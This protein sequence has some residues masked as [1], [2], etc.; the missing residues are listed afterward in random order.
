LISGSLLG[1]DSH[2]IYVK[3]GPVQRQQQLHKIRLLGPTKLIDAKTK[4]YVVEL[5]PKVQASVAVRKLLADRAFSLVWSDDQPVTRRER[6]QTVSGAKT[7]FDLIKPNLD[8]GREGIAAHRFGDKDEKGA[9]YLGGYLYFLQHRAY[10]YDRM[11]WSAYGRA[12]THASQMAPFNMGS[13]S[14]AAT[15]RHSLAVGAITASPNKWSFLGPKN[16]TFPYIWGFGQGPGSGRVNAAVY[17][18]GSSSTMYIGGAMGGLWKSTDTGNTWSPLGDAWQFMCVSSIAI[19]P[20]NTKNIYVGTGDFPGWYSFS[21]GIMKST[22]GGV[23]WTNYGNS[24]FGGSC[25]SSIL[26]DPE[27]PSI[28]TITTGD[29]GYN[30]ESPGKVW[31]ST[32]GGVTWTA[33]I[34]TVSEWSG[35][36]MSIK[37]GSGNRT[38]YVTG[39]DGN[40]QYI[41]KS[42]NRGQTWAAATVPNA[43]NSGAFSIAGSTIS[44]TTVYFFAPNSQLIYKSTDS[45]ATWSNITGNLG[46]IGDWGQAYYDYYLTVGNVNGADD[47]FVGLIDVFESTNGGTTWSSVINAYSGND[48]THVDQHC[49]TVNPSNPNDCL[50]GNDG[51]IY[52]GTRTGTA[53]SFTSLNKNMGVTQF[54]DA[55]WHPTD[56]TRMLGGAQD[57]GTP[58]SL[59]NLGTWNDVI[60][61]DGFFCAINPANPLVQ[62]GTVYNDAVVETKDGWKTSTGISPPVGAGENSPFVTYVAQDPVNTQFMYCTTQYLYRWNNATSAWTSHLGGKQLTNGGVIYAVAVAPTNGSIIY[63]GSDDGQIYLSTTGGAS[64]T[65][66]NNASLPNRSITSISVD[67]KNANSI[68]I[69]LSGSGTAHLYQCTNTAASPPIYTP[70]S[71]GGTSSLPDISLNCIT[72]DVANP[73]KV[74]YVGTD[75]GVFGTTNSGSTWQ[76]LTTPLGLPSC[77]VTAIQSMSYGALNCAT[78]GRGMWTIPTSALAGA[79]IAPYQ[80]SAIAGTFVPSPPIPANGFIQQLKADDGSLVTMSSSYNSSLNDELAGFEADYNVGAGT[81]A[82]ALVSLTIDSTSPATFQVFAYNYATGQSDLQQTFGSANS[83]TNKAFSL[84]G[85]VSNYMKNGIVRL[86]LRMIVPGRMQT[87]PDFSVDSFTVSASV[88]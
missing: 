78:Y 80:V 48:L 49:L 83:L 37:D 38:Y 61:G 71:G 88:Q 64:F 23:T 20:V 25:V 81:L 1:Q 41:M 86:T 31:R 22:D 54:Y 82:S 9:D 79:G 46:T 87:A 76:N 75:I 50:V 17:Q 34:S 3:L 62:Y 24:Q 77:E 55:S 56:S 19:D 14:G 15:G 26:V 30:V 4:T 18:P 36:T 58:V 6:M 29:G 44:A 27:N 73:A 52:H 51:G 13:S 5:G 35:A 53:W 70:V 84:S 33:A 16:L 59:G 63:T 85:T 8:E 65:S 47:L 67:T 40:S 28:V 43:P 32:N 60:G 12:L 21:Q 7:A 2:R 68:I 57:N 69:G 39:S 45:G 66:I 11:D 72:R 42:T 74:W 10:P